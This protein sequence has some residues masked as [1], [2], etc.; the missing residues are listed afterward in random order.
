MVLDG[1]TRDPKTGKK[2]YCWWC[3]SEVEEIHEAA[4]SGYGKI[5]TVV[6]Y[7][8]SFLWMLLAL[9]SFSSGQLGITVFVTMLWLVA[10]CPLFWAWW[11][12]E[13]CTIEALDKYL[14]KRLTDWDKAEYDAYVRRTG[15]HYVPS[16][17]F[18]SLVKEL[19]HLK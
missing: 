2:T 9:A 6:F 3:L 13:Q 17:R 10:V 18:V 5:M 14:N 1:F 11:M 16:D 15:R 4:T 12:L 8:W 19:A 7:A